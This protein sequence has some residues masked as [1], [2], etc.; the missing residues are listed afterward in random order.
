MFGD[1]RTS[2]DDTY[3][4]DIINGIARAIQYD[5]S[6]FEIF[7]LGNDHRV[8]LS[9]MIRIIEDALGK[10]AR[11]KQLP[12]Q[13]GD[14]RHTCASIEKSRR[15]LGYRPETSF[16]DGIAKFVEWLQS[17]QLTRN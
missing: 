2:R 3:I 7:N 13:D 6:P 14:V 11:V 10:K 1:G 12:E 16:P 9:E 15:L 17:N 5:A 8:S 4:D